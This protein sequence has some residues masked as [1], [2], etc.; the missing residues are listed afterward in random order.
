VRPEYTIVRASLYGFLAV[1]AL[2]AT[3]QFSVA[4]LLPSAL[5]GEAASTPAAQL[6]S[7]AG[8]YAPGVS[9]ISWLL[10]VCVYASVLGGMFSILTS[11]CWNVYRLALQGHLP[12]RSFLTRLTRGNVPWV[13]LLAEVGIAV[14]AVAITSQ[15]VPLQKMCILCVVFSFLCAMLAALR[16]RRADGSWLIN[17]VIVYAAVVSTLG[18]F[19]LT[20]Y[21]IFLHGVSVPYILLCGSGVVCAAWYQLVGSRV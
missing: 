14:C 16:A 3:F 5:L 18:L 20:L 17:P 21:Q 15:Q 12:A 8:I 2:L 19:G 9:F 13:S 6:I 10:T 1:A 11:N 4:A 7:I